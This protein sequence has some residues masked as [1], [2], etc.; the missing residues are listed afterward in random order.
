MTPSDIRRISKRAKLAPSSFISSIEE[1]PGRER[2]EPAVLINGIKSLIILRWADAR[3][4]IFYENGCSIYASRPMLCRTY[5]FRIGKNGLAD[6]KSRACPMRWVPD[7]AEKKRYI[8]DLRRYGK[9][10]EEYKKMADGWND[11]GG[12]TL[13]EFLAAVK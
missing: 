4:C 9:A 10:L 2:E 7:D 6:L 11:K 12:G 5:P 3:R 13:V 1:P 8:D